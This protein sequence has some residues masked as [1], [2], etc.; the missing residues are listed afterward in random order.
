MV[1]SPPDSTLAASTIPS[2]V[3]DP[4]ARTEKFSRTSPVICTSPMKSIFPVE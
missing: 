4:V 1:I 2:T 3:I